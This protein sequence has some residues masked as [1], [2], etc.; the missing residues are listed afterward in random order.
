MFDS[1]QG[2]VRLQEHF[3]KLTDPRR[4]KVTHPLINIITIAVCA[5]IGGADDFVGIADFGE[6]KKEWFGRFLDLTNGIP[7]HD[8][9]NQ[10]LAAIKPEEFA[11]CLL[12]WI[13]A[14]REV[15]GG[16]ILAIDGKTL[17]RSFDQA[18]GK[19][20]LQMVS[21]WSSANHLSL[22]QVVVDDKSSE[23]A[24]IPKL[25][26]MLELSGCLV[27]IDAAGCQVEIARQ[28]VERG[29]DYVLAVKGN[30]PTL[31]NGVIDFFAEYV[32]APESAQGRAY[33]HTSEKAHGRTA[34]WRQCGMIF[35]TAR[36][37]RDCARWV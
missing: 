4:G 13:A 31:H 1:Q 7:S 22:G 19:A 18:S 20:A 21:A 9:F 15:S 30:Q 37:G 2:R 35:P 28:I 11:E 36:A 25:L 5:V 12:S 23:I 27:T 26:E 14:L 24:A 34:S 8:R 29:A 3:Q 32:A 33:Y 16:E 17:R 10:V 6:S